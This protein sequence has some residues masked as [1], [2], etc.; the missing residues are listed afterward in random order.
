M[1]N[2]LIIRNIENMYYS[3]SMDWNRDFFAPRTCDAIVF[4]T[5]GEIEYFFSHKTL[6]ARKGE[7]L[8]LPGDLPYSGK[9]HTEKVGFFVLDFTCLKPNDFAAFGAPCTFPVHNYSSC[10]S[11]FTDALNLWNKH[12][13][14]VHFTL[15]ALLYGLLGEIKSQNSRDRILIYIMDHMDDPNLTIKQIADVFFISESQLRRNIHKETGL[16]PNEYLLTLR[17][18][19]AKS[20]LTYTDKSAKQI[21]AECGFSSPYY[22][23]RCFTKYTGTSPSRYRKLTYI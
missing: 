13:A 2:D 17:I 10:V 14:D 12:T 20:E 19:K 7:L 1:N 15:K 23:S 11:K 6:A 9:K 16:S 8:L 3:E 18:N 21:A 5:E 4:F 22:F